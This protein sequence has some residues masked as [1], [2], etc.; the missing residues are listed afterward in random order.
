MNIPILQ[1]RTYSLNLA[2]DALFNGGKDDPAFIVA[3]PA[4]NMFLLNKI[5]PFLSLQFYGIKEDKLN[6]KHFST[7]I[8][9]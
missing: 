9:V 7:A 5:A 8:F 4:K 1:R 3:K 6:S 2:L